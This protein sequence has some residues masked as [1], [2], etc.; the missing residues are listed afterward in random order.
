MLRLLSLRAVVNRSTLYELKEG[1][2]VMIPLTEDAIATD[3]VITNGFHSS[4]KLQLKFEPTSTYFFQV[5]AVVN[6]AGLAAILGVSLLLFVLYAI[7]GGS[8][9]LV[10]A[11]LPVL[12][13]VWLFFLNPSRAIVLKPWLPE[14][15]A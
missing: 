10:M 3:L 8:I 1:E 9:L 7:Y 2:P 15:S 5:N 12:A 13:L 11:N 14:N 4:E 6:N